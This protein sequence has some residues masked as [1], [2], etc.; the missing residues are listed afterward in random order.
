M[1]PNH[2]EEGRGRDGEPKTDFFTLSPRNTLKMGPHM[3][4]AQPELSNKQTEKNRII[5][6]KN[7]V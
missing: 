2:R 5:W 3:I 4:D 6:T 1:A 7:V